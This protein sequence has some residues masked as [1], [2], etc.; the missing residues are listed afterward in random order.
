M[1]TSN[2]N[3]SESTTVITKAMREHA[4]DTVRAFGKMANAEKSLSKCFDLLFSDG[5]RA[6]DTYSPFTGVN[7]LPKDSKDPKAIKYMI[8]VDIAVATLSTAQQKL[9]TT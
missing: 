3:V 9:L 5:L 7:K 8:F 4:S 2:K 1:T 6:K